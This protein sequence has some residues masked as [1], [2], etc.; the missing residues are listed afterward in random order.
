ME[1]IVP[2]GHTGVITYR[3]YADLYYRDFFYYTRKKRGPSSLIMARPVDTIDQLVYLSYAPHDVMFSG[4][5]GDQTGDFDGLKAALNNILRS[6]WRGY[7]NFG[8]D[9]G[10]YRTDNSKL[11]RTKEVFTRWFQ[12]GSLLPLMENGGNGE[13]RPWIFGIYYSLF[14]FSFNLIIIIFFVYFYNRK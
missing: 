3:E 14:K 12:L 4:W 8:C 7:L 9:I 11:G 5:V 6:A 13:H 2:K 10:G 1:L